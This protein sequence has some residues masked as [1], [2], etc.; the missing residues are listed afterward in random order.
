MK[1]IFLDRDGVINR[2]PGHK[3]Y[4]TKIKDFSFIPGALKAI[5]NLSDNNFRIFVIS[6]QAGVS[7]GIYSQKKLDAITD[8]MLQKVFASGAKI[9]GVFYCVHRPEDNCSCRKSKIG[10]I[11]KAL[12]GLKLKSLASTYF[13]GDSILDVLTGKNAGMKTILVLSGK[14]KKKNQKLWQVKPDFVVRDLLAATKIVI[15]EDP[16][17]LCLGRRR[18]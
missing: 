16:H 14:E 13:I 5:K 4:V 6:N 7:K 17:S 9:K 1:I 8:L 2:Y 12:V 10:M 15:N 11:K 18:A 3:N